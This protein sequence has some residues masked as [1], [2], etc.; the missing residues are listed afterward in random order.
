MSELQKKVKEVAKKALL[1]FGDT[2]RWLARYDKQCACK[3]LPNVG[4]LHTIKCVFG[5][6]AEK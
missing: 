6:T 1:E 3:V 5:D 2:F 4:K